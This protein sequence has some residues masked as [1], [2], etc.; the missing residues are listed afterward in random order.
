MRISKENFVV[1]D[2]KEIKEI[3]RKFK[4]VTLKLVDSCGYYLI[5]GTEEEILLSTFI[6]K[7]SKLD[8]F[9]SSNYNIFGKVITHGECIYIAFKQS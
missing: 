3:E 1:F 8:R 9:L 7:F 2:E 4:Y 6:D 5:A